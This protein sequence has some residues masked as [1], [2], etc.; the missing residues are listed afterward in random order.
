MEPSFIFFPSSRNKMVISPQI[1]Q[2]PCSDCPIKAFVFIFSS[3][4]SEEQYFCAQH[5]WGWLLKKV[6]ALLHEQIFFSLNMCVQPADRHNLLRPETIESLFYMYRFTKD[7]KYRDWGWD[8]LQSFNNYTRVSENYKK[9]WSFFF[10]FFL[11]LKK[12]TYIY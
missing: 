12:T 1:V 10:F 6:G 8:I 3:I 7:S 2:K 5:W 11:C 4:C 9:L